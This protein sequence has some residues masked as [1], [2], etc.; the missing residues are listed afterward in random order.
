MAVY[1]ALSAA[2]MWQGSHSAG[3]KNIDRSLFAVRFQV[4]VQHREETMRPATVP[5]KSILF[6]KHGA[7]QHYTS[8]VDFL[9]EFIYRTA[10]NRIAEAYCPF[11]GILPA[12]TRAKATGDSRTH[13]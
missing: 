10:C 3:L 11:Y 6:Y 5:C 2:P 7:L 12:E 8:A 1:P 4:R 13:I 9:T